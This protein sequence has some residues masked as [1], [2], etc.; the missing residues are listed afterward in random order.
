MEQGAAPGG[1]TSAVELA[2]QCA[3]AVRDLAWVK[4]PDDGAPGLRF[5][6]DVHVTVGLLAR[7]CRDLPQAVEH[8]RL[9]LDQQA[10]QHL[11][12]AWDADR[13]GEDLPAAL[14]QW[15]RDLAAVASAAA[16]LE[17]ALTQAQTAIR[18]LRQA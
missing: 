5:P 1:P 6:G 18:H 13:T 2:E 12:E 4:H 10:A 7:A 16:A 17:Q 11:V 3:Q 9:W 8:L 14:R 15:Q